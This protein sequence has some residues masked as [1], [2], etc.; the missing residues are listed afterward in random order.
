MDL[1][2]PIPKITVR[3][4]EYNA[5]TPRHSLKQISILIAI[6]A[7]R[8]CDVDCLGLEFVSQDALMGAD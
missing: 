3:L 1:V 5:N 8:H 7:L 4:K 2:P 6:H